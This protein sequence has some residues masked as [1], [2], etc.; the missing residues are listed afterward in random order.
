MVAAGAKVKVGNGDLG[1]FCPQPSWEMSTL[2]NKRDEIGSSIYEPILVNIQPRQRPWEVLHEEG[3]GSR[4]QSCSPGGF[5]GL[6]WRD[7]AWNYWN[8]PLHNIWMDPNMEVVDDSSLYKPA[9]IRLLHMVDE[10][11][12]PLRVNK[13]IPILGSSHIYSHLCSIT[14]KK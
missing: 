8:H 13:V 7:E 2:P 10:L 6:W 14:T 5:T 1:F 12:L 3:A 9:A 4:L 11:L